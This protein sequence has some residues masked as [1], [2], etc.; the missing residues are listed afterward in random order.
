MTPADRLLARIA[1]ESRSN[2]AAFRQRASTFLALFGEPYGGDRKQKPLARPR[3]PN[4]VLALDELRQNE[5]RI[6]E[7]L[8]EVARL[9]HAPGPRRDPAPERALGVTTETPLRAAAALSAP[10][11][12]RV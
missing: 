6:V 7:L 10:R 12:P 1:N 5:A 4:R 2:L 8:A 3:R 9:S 11:S